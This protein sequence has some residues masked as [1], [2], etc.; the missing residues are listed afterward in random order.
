M[1]KYLITCSFVI[2]FVN[3]ILGQNNIDSVKNSG[4]FISEKIIKYRKIVVD[5]VSPTIKIEWTNNEY[6]TKYLKYDSISRF[7]KVYK[8]D[9]CLI[10]ENK[11]FLIHITD[12][13]EVWYYTIISKVHDE[14][15]FCQ[16]KILIGSIYYLTLYKTDDDLVN[17]L[18][19][20]G[21]PK[22]VTINEEM[23]FFY[24]NTLLFKAVTTNDI[25]GLCFSP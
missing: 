4:A 1:I 16:N 14:N 22:I 20:G 8:I 19:I 12:L 7:Y 10:R 21:L 5:T 9:T 2:L 23:L 11:Y 17:R 15:I 25:K 3:D 6:L 13:S 18:V 24:G